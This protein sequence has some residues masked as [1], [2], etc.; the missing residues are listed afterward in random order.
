VI[1]YTTFELP[2]TR[3]TITI[4]GNE[5]LEERMAV[6]YINIKVNIKIMKIEF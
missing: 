2:C 3:G 1:F 6:L 5:I 4:A